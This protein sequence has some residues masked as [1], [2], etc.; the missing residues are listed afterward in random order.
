M[1]KLIHADLYK[2]FH[3][4]YFY[5]MM[6]ALVVL[7]VIVNSAMHGSGQYGTASFSIMFAVSLLNLPVILMPM[8]TEIV[9][10]EEYRDHTIKNTLSFGTNRT[11]L[12]LSKYI[13]AVIL[14]VILM[15]VVLGS[16]FG[17]MMI[18]LPKDPKFTSEII[19]EFFIRLG[20]S[21]TVYLACISMAVFFTVL[22]NR[23]TMA[24]FLYYG[25][26]YLTEY[27]LYLFH[28]SK[29]IDYLLKTQISNIMKLPIIQLQNPVVISL[30]TLL[31][32]LMAG[33]ALFRKRDVC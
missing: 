5:I 1:L 30:V 31:V 21:C 27:L 10:A 19:R 24:I 33:I 8:L 6:L 13:C 9:S 23:S 29:G 11:L 25:V 17:S 14:G 32:F 3:R 2:V 12:F 18:F 4:M 26:F 20:A 28:F 15:A 22:F 16:Y 7:C